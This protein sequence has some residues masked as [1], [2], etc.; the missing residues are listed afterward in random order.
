[1]PQNNP[2]KPEAEKRPARQTS[3]SEGPIKRRQ[4]T[5]AQMPDKDLPRGSEPE[6]HA[7]SHRR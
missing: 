2:R 1:M 7:S 4:V 6:T 3:E 5:D